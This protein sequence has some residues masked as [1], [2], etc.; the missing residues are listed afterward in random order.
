MPIPYLGSKR[1][2]A[3]VL[4]QTIKNATGRRDG[5]LVD[6]FCGGFAVGEYFLKQGW[7]VIANDKNRYVIALLRDG[8]PKEKVE[9]FVKR[10]E[11][12]DVLENPALYED[13]YVG[14][15]MCIWSFGNNQTWYLYGKDV[16]P[17][18][19]ACHEL[20]V[21]K[22]KEY[23]ETLMPLLPKTYISALVRLDTW[24]KRRIALSRIS[25]MLKT[26]ML[27][28]QH[29]EH[30]ERLEQVEQLKRLKRVKENVTFSSLDYKDV[31][32]PEGALVYCDPPYEGRAEYKEN[33]FTH[34]E[35]WDWVR[36]QS[37]KNAIYVS[38]YNAPPDFTVVLQFP[39]NSGLCSGQNKNQPPERL[40]TYGG[41][42]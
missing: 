11:F 33:D 19:Y 29:L 37:K 14:Y 20:V 38:E 12:L 6:L 5:V 31:V 2:L 21:N 42:H 10:D 27:Y 1:K 16:E 25:K 17:Y 32:I 3:G 28:L 7:R 36:K 18:K 39:Q 40:F 13:W 30:L 9:R 26:S 24:H 22:N 34:Q 8:L 15:V 35:F 41:L 4:Y 23:I